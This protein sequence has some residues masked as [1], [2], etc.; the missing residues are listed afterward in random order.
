MWP[1][2]LRHLH[3]GGQAWGGGGFWAWL[4]CPT[5]LL[6]GG[7]SVVVG[8]FGEGGGDTE[9]LL[10]LLQ[11]GT[12]FLC[13]CQLLLDLPLPTHTI[14]GGRTSAINRN[15]A[16]PIFPPPN[17]FLPGDQALKGTR[18]FRLIRT[19]S[20]QHPSPLCEMLCCDSLLPA[21]GANPAPCPA[22]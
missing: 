2:C 10:P 15:A 19:F 12:L 17:L 4:D 14:A 7:C 13:T 22:G 5:L 11:M 3:L 18:H 1:I 8:F 9:L 20:K 6:R 16:P 21:D